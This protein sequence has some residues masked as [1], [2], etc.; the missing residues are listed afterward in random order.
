[1]DTN[2]DKEV[3]GLKVMP[4]EN[5]WDM[6]EHRGDKVIILRETLAQ[7]ATLR[8]S[9]TGSRQIPSRLMNNDIAVMTA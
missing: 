3:K 8:E 1:M 7:Q 2:S 5:D 4:D 6:A 9:L